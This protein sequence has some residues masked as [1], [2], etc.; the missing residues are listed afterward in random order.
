[1]QACEYCGSDLP[2]GASFCGYCGRAPSYTTDSPTSGDDLP[3][4]NA[5]TVVTS[6]P[7]N[8]FYNNN[9]LQQGEQGWSR[10]NTPPQNQDDEEEGR[11][12]RAALLGLGLPLAGDMGQHGSNAPTVQGLPQAGVPMVQGTPQAPPNVMGQGAAQAWNS[13]PTVQAPQA[14][15][16]APGGY[17]T[18]AP[19]KPPS[20]KPNPGGC[21]PV[22]LIFIVAIILIIASIIGAGFTVFAP[23]IS[24]SGGSDVAPGG[25]LHLHGSSFLPGSSITLTI[26]GGT[27][28]YLSSKE[29]QQQ[30]TNG[31]HTM[32]GL[33]MNAI[34]LTR[35]PGA[36]NV[37]KA[38]GDGSFNVNIPVGQDWHTGTHTIHA[39]EGVRSADLSFNVHAPGTVTPSPS[40]TTSPTVTV[41]PSPSASPTG[42]SCI[43]PSA[44]TFG[45]ISEGYNQPLSTK[46]TLCTTGTTV[47]NWTAT[48]D[49]NA[50]SWLQVDPTTGQ[51]SAPGNQDVTIS[52][53]ATGLKAATYNAT[54]TFTS[55]QSNKPVTLSVTFIIQSGCINA[56]PNS[57]TFNGVA[58]VSDPA[59]QAVTV[60]NC[61]NP[62]TW[63]V[64]VVTDHNTDWLSVSPTGGTLDGQG[65]QS[66]TVTASNLKAQLATGT[67]TAKINFCMGSQQYTVNVTLNVQAGSGPKLVLYSPSNTPPSISAKTDCKRSSTAAVWTCTATIG[68]SS[69]STSLDWTPSSTGVQGITFNPTNGTLTP[70]QTVQVEIIVPN[71]DCQT[72]T[73]ITFTGPANAIDIAWSC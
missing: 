42:F 66:V 15:A 29:R 51:I 72:A 47:V 57:L 28:L 20:P 7:N 67:Y 2:D 61:G 6:G 14:G 9:T 11:R 1:M 48:W 21:V 56:A 12:K 45:P 41:A 24:L 63:S 16:P 17:A 13:A 71:N 32:P 43:N 22:W 50:A 3:A 60:T 35:L 26:D 70:G 23:S 53:V 44:I 52:A 46:I 18:P 33:A 34:A 73:T 30:I 55:A 64:T 54:V 59:A 27:P 36:S 31:V 38:G 68:N 19:H 25:L 69:T 65:T 5:P 62:G 8:P 40:A 58:G 10:E 37:V 39:S 4:I 49:S